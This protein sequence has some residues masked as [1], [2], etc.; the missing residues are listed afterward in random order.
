MLSGQTAAT[1]SFSPL[2][3]S[4]ADSY[5]CEASGTVASGTPFIVRQIQGVFLASEFGKVY[6]IV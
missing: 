6:C 4:N 5:S 3:L 2:R 1:L